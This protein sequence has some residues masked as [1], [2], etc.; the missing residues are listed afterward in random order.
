[1]QRRRLWS[2]RI[3]VIAVIALAVPGT[4]AAAA[5]NGFWYLRGFGLWLE[6]DLDYRTTTEEGQHVRAEAESDFGLGVSGEFQFSRRLG[7]ELGIFRATPAIDLRFDFPDLA[8]SA[9]S[10]DELTI[11]SATLGLNIHLT[12]KQRFDVYVGPLLAYIRYSDL[13]FDVRANAVV[14][15]VPIV[16][17]DHIRLEV[18]YDNAIGGVI[19]VDAPIR[20]EGWSVSAR[21]SYLATELDV[22]GD[23]G[24]RR[25]LDFDPLVIGI[26]MSFRF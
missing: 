1:M 9:T 10:S 17:E 11:T 19:G 14:D 12:P 5:G 21:V 4:S 22:T 26:G 3:L 24:E 7:V 15:E 25:V 8:L 6:P 16:L 2:C 20:W 18:D 23:D 13:Q